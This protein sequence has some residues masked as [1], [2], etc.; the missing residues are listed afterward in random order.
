MRARDFKAV[1]VY[2]EGY[3]WRLGKGAMRQVARGAS[4]LA[5]GTLLAAAYN[6]S[7]GRWSNLP[8]A[9]YQSGPWTRLF[10]VKNGYEVYSYDEQERIEELADALFI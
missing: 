5:V 2:G 1:Y 3:L 4:P 8:A 9:L 6:Y 7:T 10:A